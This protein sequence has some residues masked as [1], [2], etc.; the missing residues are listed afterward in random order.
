MKL[1][2]Q[3]ATLV[4]VTAV[5][6]VSASPATAARAASRRAVASVATRNAPYPAPV[7]ALAHDG[8]TSHNWSGYAAQ[9]SSQFTEV[10]GRWVQPS[11]T[12]SS[13]GRSAAAF[14]IGLDGYTSD[15]VEQ[16]GTKSVCD[17]ETPAYTAW[18]QMYPA[19]PTFLPASSYPV[20]PADTLTA[21][22]TRSGMSYRL[23]I[24][25]SEGWTYSTVQTGSA[26]NS[27][28]E[29]IASSPP[30][31]ATC[32]GFAS[33]ADFGEVEFSCAEA[34][35]GGPLRAVSSFRNDDGPAR[36]TM[37]GTG[38]VILAKPGRLTDKGRT[39]QV[40]WKAG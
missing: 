33:L 7:D 27:S 39:F 17:D 2:L 37:V 19:A 26:A 21:S 4:L 13:S 10:S 23:T 5:T 15:T 40:L 25:S 38:D 11:V 24:A 18:W 8:V 22:V 12:C 32:R 30:A 31:C 9:A 16:I 3:V 28:A 6:M 34:A 36:I 1:R 29:W 20:R 35:V 14:W